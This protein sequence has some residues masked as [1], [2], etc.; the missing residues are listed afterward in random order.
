MDLSKY[1]ISKDNKDLQVALT[2]TSYANEH[3]IESYEKGLN[4]NK[5]FFCKAL[6]GFRDRCLIN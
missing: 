6:C 3:N 2:H 1:G 5:D 4:P